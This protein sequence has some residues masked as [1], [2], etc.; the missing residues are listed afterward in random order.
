MESPNGT[1]RSFTGNG[2]Q[3]CPPTQLGATASK[4]W[5][6]KVMWQMNW[7]CWIAPEG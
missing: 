7:M 4:I 2:T 3:A 1:E 6:E 5:K